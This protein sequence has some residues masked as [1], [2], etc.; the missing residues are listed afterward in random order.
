MR[1]AGAGCRLQTCRRGDPQRFNSA[2]PAATFGDCN[3][4]LMRSYPSGHG[5][6][7][8]IQW[9]LPA[10]VRT[11]P[12]AHFHFRCHNLVP[13]NSPAANLRAL[14]SVEERPFRIREVEGSNPSVSTFPLRSHQW[15]RLSVAQ[16]VEH[17]TVDVCDHRVAGSIP[18]AETFQG[19]GCRRSLP[20][21]VG[22]AQGS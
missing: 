14:S 17:V 11:L 21:S 9:A 7:L 2:F 8:E 12:I 22:R 13:H 5:A 3:T 4:C 15:E 6:G 1:S 18:A 20:S 10:Q 19:H 16:L